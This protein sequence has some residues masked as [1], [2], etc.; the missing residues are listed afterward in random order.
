[1]VAGITQSGAQVHH[2]YM[3]TARWIEYSAGLI[4]THPGG[5][6]NFNGRW[7][8]TQLSNQVQNYEYQILG[9]DG[10][11]LKAYTDNNVHGI[12]WVG[13]VGTGTQNAYCQYRFSNRSAE[14]ALTLTHIAGGSSGNSNIPYM[15]NDG[16][17]CPA[18]KMDH[19]GDYN[20]VIDVMVIGGKSSN[21]TYTAYSYTA[22]P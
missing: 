21:G 1:M 13:I 18:W 3:G 4:G 15:V 12:I 11:T 19:S 6:G 8:Y 16:N 10:N 22:N 17:N 9:P 7:R 14:N 2:E 20:T 5:G